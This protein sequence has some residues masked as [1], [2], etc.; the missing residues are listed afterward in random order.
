MLK[1]L[2][3]LALILTLASTPA[4]ADPEAAC[5]LPPDVPIKATLQ[6]ETPKV[7]FEL[8]AE[9]LGSVGGSANTTYGSRY[10]GTLFVTPTNSYNIEPAYIGRTD[11]Q[12]C[13]YIKAATYSFT[14]KEPIIYISSNVD[15]DSCIYE[16]IAKNELRAVTMYQTLLAD[17][18]PR[19]QAALDAAIRG[20]GATITKDIQ[21]ATDSAYKSIYAA[22]QGVD[23]LYSEELVKQQLALTSPEVLAELKKSCDGAFND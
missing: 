14:L 18:Q 6:I 22:I 23:K 20:I 11:G 1:P 21:T 3:F 19:Y 15:K 10:G 17:Y 4:W 2:P 9:Q 8:K 5:V 13:F 7:S 16:A 12:Y